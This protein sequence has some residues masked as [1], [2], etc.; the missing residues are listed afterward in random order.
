MQLTHK[1][2]QLPVLKVKGLLALTFYV[3][4]AASI[5]NYIWMDRSVSINDP[6][7]L[8]PARL[9]FKSKEGDAHAQY[10]LG[11]LYFSGH[12]VKSNDQRAIE[13]FKSSAQKGHVDAQF[14]VCNMLE[15]IEPPY[16]FNMCIK[17]SQQRHVE[18][19]AKTGYWFVKGP[20]NEQ[21]NGMKGAM[22]LTAASE[23][24]HAVAMHN[25]AQLYKNGAGIPEDIN[26]AYYWVSLS[27]L[28]EKDENV[29]ANLVN[30]ISEWG[31]TIKKDK[32]EAL[33]AAVVQRFNKGFKP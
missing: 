14:Q 16:A 30:T 2:K 8:D 10:L 25:L 7:Y 31:A 28:L 21:P 33:D 27:A 20:P 5:G 13:L 24:G 9:E 32:R 18:A 4:I 26:L 29:K 22:Y 11:M 6:A 17:A 1:L 3:G 12:N 23:L 19:L 15:A